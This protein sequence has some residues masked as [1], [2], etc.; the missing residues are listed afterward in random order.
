[1][2]VHRLPCLVLQVPSAPPSPG[3]TMLRG[4]EWI[5]RVKINA[6]TCPAAEQPKCQ[7]CTTGGGGAVWYLEQSEALSLR[8]EGSA[9]CHFLQCAFFFTTPVIQALSTVKRDDDARPLMIG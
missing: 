1:M 6:H 5:R 7:L 8:K 4:G 3:G 9:G 2:S